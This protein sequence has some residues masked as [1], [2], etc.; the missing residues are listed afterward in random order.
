[1]NTVTK[2]PSQARQGERG[3]PMLAVIDAAFK[4]LKPGG[5][6]VANMA[7]LEN[8]SQATAQ[9]RRLTTDLSVLLV[10]VARGVQQLDS[11]RFEAVNPSFLLS[12]AKT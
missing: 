1:M 3:R 10:N 8:V 2:R 4:Q 5:V 12:V 9:L 11:I 7:T 6:L